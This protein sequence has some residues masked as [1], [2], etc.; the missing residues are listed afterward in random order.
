[1]RI[2]SKKFPD[3]G[4]ELTFNRK[5]YPVKNLNITFEKKINPSDFG[6]CIPIPDKDFRGVIDLS[7]NKINKK[8]FY[9]AKTIQMVGFTYK[10]YYRNFKIKKFY[11]KK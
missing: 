3:L 4:V 2:I 7:G 5:K 11:L 8:M 10:I 9:S 1:M 6:K